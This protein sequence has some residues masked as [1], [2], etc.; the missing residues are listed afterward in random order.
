MTRRRDTVAQILKRD[1]RQKISRDIINKTQDK[2]IK[3]DHQQDTQIFGGNLVSELHPSRSSQKQTAP[4]H[5][6]KSLCHGSPLFQMKIHC[7]HLIVAVFQEV[8]IPARSFSLDGEVS[9]GCF[10]AG[11]FGTQSFLMLPSCGILAQTHP[12]GDPLGSPNSYLR[13]F[14]LATDL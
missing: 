11:T 3:R 4:L 6:W 10:K 13:S 1:F 12:S 2:D 9:F 14:T 5:P 7:C 8:D